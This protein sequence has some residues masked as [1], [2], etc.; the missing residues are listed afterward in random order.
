MQAWTRL[1]ERER[2]RELGCFVNWTK[3]RIRRVQLTG[4]GLTRARATR[5]RRR[6]HCLA[7]LGGRLLGESRVVAVSLDFAAVYLPRPGGGGG[8]GENWRFK[9]GIAV[10]MKGVTIGRSWLINRP[11]ELNARVKKTLR[12]MTLLRFRKRG[13]AFTGSRHEVARNSST[14]EMSSADLQRAAFSEASTK[15]KLQI[16]NF[17]AAFV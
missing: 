5:F 14:R 9:R 12:L 11:D 4:T 16:P 8:G 6:S 10:F 7:R 2:E 17:S 3:L 15:Q 13:C 1:R